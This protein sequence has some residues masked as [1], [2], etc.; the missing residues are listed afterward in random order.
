MQ[1]TNYVRSIIIEEYKHR[2]YYVIYAE[3]GESQ[4]NKRTE[5]SR[6]YFR[7]GN[8]VKFSIFMKMFSTTQ[9]CEE[10]INA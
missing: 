9:Y 3:N 1:K 10:I 2:S 5:T 4:T 6:E 8:V 7:A